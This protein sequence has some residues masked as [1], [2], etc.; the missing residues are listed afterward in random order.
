[1]NKERRKILQQVI[2]KLEDINSEL[3]NLS[4]EEKEAYENI[5]E[6]LNNTD[7]A[8]NMYEVAEILDNERGNIEDVIDN[9]QEIIDSY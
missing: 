6:N 7:R 3:G 9:L 4:D 1:M 8:N 5:P 2:E